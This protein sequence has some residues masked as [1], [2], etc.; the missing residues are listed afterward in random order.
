[1]TKRCSSQRGVTVLELLITTVIIGIVSAMAVPR[2]QIAMDRLKIRGASQDMSSA[3]KL[4]RSY[5]ISNKDPYGLQ[6]NSDRLTVTL[7]EDRAGAGAGI[8]DVTDTVIRV[9]TLPQE[10]HYLDT[11]CDNDLVIFR[12]N[13]SAVF[14]GGGNIYAIAYTDRV[15]GIILSNVLAST[16][17]VSTENYIY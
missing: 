4:A 1:M 14:T 7:F 8:F 13:G 17:R 10:F 5:A 12:P 3:M 16:G 15:T 11:D 9:D 6:F 2:F